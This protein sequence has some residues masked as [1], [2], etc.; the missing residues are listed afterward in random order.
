MFSL[1]SWNVCLK[2]LVSQF[3][4][5]TRWY[6]VSAGRKDRFSHPAQPQI[7]MK[8]NLDFVLQQDFLNWKGQFLSSQGL[9]LSLSQLIICTGCPK[10]KRTFRT[11]TA[12]SAAL[13]P[14]REA[15]HQSPRRW[16]ASLTGATAALEAVS[17]LKVR[18]FWDTLYI[19]S[20]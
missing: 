20:L 8:I 17:V 14:V 16:A 13:V 10:K 11:E 9:Y 2:H 1:M 19:L 4:Y 5:F 6:E 3:V 15:A 7:P 18:F 12:S